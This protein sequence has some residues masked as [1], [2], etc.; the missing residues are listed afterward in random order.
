MLRKTPFFQSVILMLTIL[1]NS[2]GGLVSSIADLSKFSHALLSRTLDLTPTEI[3][4][5]LKPAS[6]AGGPYDSVGMPWEI[7][8]PF[9]LTPA[10][11]HTVTVYGKGGGAQG[12][13]SQLDV[14]DEYGFALVVLTAGD[15]QAVTLL[16]DAMLATFVPAVDEV[17][18]EQAK[19]YE[20]NYTSEESGVLVEAT[21]S[22]DDDS[23]LLSS[24]TR[25]NSDILTAL[26]DIW[27]L[28]MGTFIAPV[29]PTVRL[30]P[31]KLT[32]NTTLEDSPAT[33]EVWRL[34]PEI[35]EEMQTDLPRTG[36]V[37]QQCVIWTIGDWVHYGGEPL[38]RVVV[39]K[40]E[41]EVVGFEVPFL[42]SGVLKAE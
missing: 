32:M 2:G 23:L 41:G 35:T 39:Y 40:E 30:F 7:F 8:R 14:V 18:R 22:Q 42:R 36:L 10:H 38:D 19:Q 31:S 1:F 28:T 15:M 13:R 9:N 29:G 21:L 5:W 16:R 24:I 11:P 25:N 4:A 26:T 12:Y 3:D 37:S 17:S 33:A 34:W 27:T 20:R 6:F